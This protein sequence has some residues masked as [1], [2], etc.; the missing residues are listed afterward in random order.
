MITNRRAVCRRT[1]IAWCARSNQSQVLSPPSSLNHSFPTPSNT[2][3]YICINSAREGNENLFT[4]EGGIDVGNV[5]AKLS[6][7][8]SQSTLN[9]HRWR[10]SEKLSLHTFRKA[11]EIPWSTS[12][13][14]F[15]LS[16]S[17]YTL[18]TLKSTLSFALMAL[19]ASHLLFIISIWPPSSIRYG[20]LVGIF[21]RFLTQTAEL[22]CG[23]QW[24]IARDL[25]VY[26]ATT[27][28]SG[29]SADREPP[30]AFS[31]AFF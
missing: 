21:V 7:S 15:I 8:P 31:C 13:S 22:I 19:M 17:I 25:P 3:S 2:E 26:D 18:L 6:G 30:M 5:N 27:T 16:T 23:P 20:S 12:S 4:H 10:R 28:K 1:L 24:A 9:S 29:I 14:D 11:R